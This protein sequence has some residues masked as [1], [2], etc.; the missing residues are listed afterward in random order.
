M[1]KEKGFQSAEVTHEI[2]RGRRRP[3]AGATSSSTCRKGRRSRSAASTS[4]ATRRSP[5]A[6]LRRQMKENRAHWFLSLI[7]GRGTYQETKFEEDAER[8]TEFY[9]DHGYVRAQVGEPELKDLGD[10]KDKKTRWIE[11][12]DPGHRRQPLSRQQLRRRRQHGRQDRGADAALQAEEGRLLQPEAGAE[13]V[14]EGAG[15][16]RRRRLHGVHRLSGLQVQR[17]AQSGRAQDA[18]GARRGR[19]DRRPKAVRRPSTSRCRIQEGKQY[20][21]NRIIFTGNTTTRDNVIRREL[22]LYENGVFNTEAL[23]YSIKRLNQLGYFKPLEGPGKDVNID[24]TP[25]VDNKVDVK[26]KLEEQNRNQ[27]TFGAGVSQFEGFFGQLSFQTANFLG[28]GESLTVSLQ[29]GQRAQN[30]TVAFTE[31]FLF[32]RNITGGANLFR[33][34]VR[35]VGQFTQ[36]IDRRRADVR[37]PGRATASRACS[38]T[39]AT[40]A[41]GSPRSARSYTDPLAARAKSVPARFAADRRRAASA[42]SAR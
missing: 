40:S 8:V 31:P 42:S 36:Q 18:G 6:R 37:V 22:R 9:R 41:C 15:D 35:Y 23:K 24:K 1:M 5:T 33:Q 17:R 3:Q 32:D 25:N 12:R 26:M 4:P 14:P 11:L 20:F 39:T 21:V 30:Y 16:L 13:R 28:R 29:G 19:V 34:D 10:S 38:R 7:T 27:L 2:T